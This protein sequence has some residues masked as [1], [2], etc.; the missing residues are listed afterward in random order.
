MNC[1]GEGDFFVISSQRGQ[2]SSGE[3]WDRLGHSKA[4]LDVLRQCVHVSTSCLNAGIFKASAE[5]TVL[6]SS[7]QDLSR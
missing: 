2:E 4:R 6:T 1:G 3:T 7:T 5:L